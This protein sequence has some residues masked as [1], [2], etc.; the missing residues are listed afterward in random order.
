MVEE[1]ATRRND[2]TE[3]TVKVKANMQFKKIFEAA[4]K[5]FGKEPNTFR[6]V[7]DGNR[8]RPEDTPAEV[9]PATLCPKLHP[10]ARTQL[11]LE[12]GDVIDALI[13]QVRSPFWYPT[14]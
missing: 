6:F 8:L 14:A 10:T 1:G 4:E 5:R 7:Y 9:R 12:D 3:I 11:N 2:P 13:Q